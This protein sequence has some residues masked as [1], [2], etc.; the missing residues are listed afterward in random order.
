MKNQTTTSTSSNVV[1]N[2]AAGTYAARR[3]PEVYDFLERAQKSAMLGFSPDW[4]ENFINSVTSSD[5]TYPPYDL[6]QLDDDHYR[7]VL[8]VAG[9]TKDEMTV[10]IEKQVLTIS[11]E[12][13]PNNIDKTDESLMSSTPTYIH[14]G[15]AMRKFERQF[16]LADNVVISAEKGASFENGLLS[17]DLVHVIPESQKPKKIPIL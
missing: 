5:K 11:G 9:F 17:I 6:I 14:R 13:K 1:N 3:L 10:S 2:N 16:I 8:A 4:R 15:I 7:V 12:K